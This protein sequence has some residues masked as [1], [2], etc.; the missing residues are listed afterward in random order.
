[1][2]VLF[3]RRT[4]LLFLDRTQ[5]EYQVIDPPTG[6]EP[7]P[8][9][10]GAS[11]EDLFIY[12]ANCL[13][14]EQQQRDKSY[15]Q[16]AAVDQTSF[17]AA[18]SAN[19]LSA[20]ATSRKKLRLSARR[21][22]VFGHARLQ[23]ERASKALMLGRRDSAPQ[24]VKLSGVKKRNHLDGFCIAHFKVPGIGISIRTAILSGRSG[25]K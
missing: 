20:D 25:V 7:A 18:I 10:A 22:R 2:V 15:C 19:G 3:T 5:D 8:T 1:M 4:N 12:P 11:G 14:A 6:I 13:S 16:R 17:D 9:S 21:S 24:I 23:R